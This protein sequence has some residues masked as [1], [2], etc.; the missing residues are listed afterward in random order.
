MISPV[1][2]TQRPMSAREQRL[3]DHER[4]SFIFARDARQLTEI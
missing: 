2:D 3:L 1:D 4:M